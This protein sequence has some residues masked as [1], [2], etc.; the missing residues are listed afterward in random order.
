MQVSR[1]GGLLALILLE[2][3]HECG[4]FMTGATCHAGAEAAGR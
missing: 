2:P 1:R 4:I 3:G